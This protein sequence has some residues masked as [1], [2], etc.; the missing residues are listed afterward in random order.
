MARCT[1]RVVL[2]VALSALLAGCFV[3]ERPML[4][5]TS[6]APALGD[7]GR[8]LTFEMRDGRSDPDETIEVRRRGDGRY[9]FIDEKQRETP[10]SFHAIPGGLHVA[11]LGPDSDK[12]GYG[13]AI[14]R[15][16][17]SEVLVH[18]L[19]CEK[20]DAA[21]LAAHGVERRDR[22]CILDGVK[23]PVALFAAAKLGEP[24]SKM[25]RQ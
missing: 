17:G 8:Y 21:L 13:Y 14:F 6:A 7:G 23:D 20:Q 9:G 10:V 5:L 12:G 3:S 2:I 25:V 16:N 1:L 24:T 11:Q 4:P 22:E 19:D 15:V 18:V